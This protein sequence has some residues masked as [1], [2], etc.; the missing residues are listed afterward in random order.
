MNDW[1]RVPVDVQASIIEW[2]RE[3]IHLH[4]EKVFV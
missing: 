1:I 2:I 3:P 4:E